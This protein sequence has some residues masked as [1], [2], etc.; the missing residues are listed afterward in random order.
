MLCCAGRET[1]RE[2]SCGSTVR[3]VL[4]KEPCYS[5]PTNG[6]PPA[7]RSRNVARQRLRPRGGKVC[8]AH[9]DEPVYC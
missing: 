6:K 7:H 1:L 3:K 9:P 4:L 2:R 5:L 8:T